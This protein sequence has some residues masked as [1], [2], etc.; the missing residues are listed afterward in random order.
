MILGPDGYHA[1]R[2]IEYVESESKCS[3]VAVRLPIEW[4][5]RGSL[6]SNSN[7]FSSC[8]K[9]IIEPEQDLLEQ[10]RTWYELKSNLREN[11]NARWSKTPSWKA[12]G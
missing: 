12:L 8:F 7:C 4:V 5:L 3:P 10:L 6:P 9:A 2:P 11:H 1:T